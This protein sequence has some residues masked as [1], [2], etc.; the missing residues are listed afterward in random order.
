MR[1]VKLSL[2][3][4]ISRLRRESGNSG[5]RSSNLG[6][7]RATSGSRPDTVSMRSS[8]GYFSLFEA[9]RHAPST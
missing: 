9:G 2:S 8:A 7:L 6:R 4:T 3:P 5:V 1:A